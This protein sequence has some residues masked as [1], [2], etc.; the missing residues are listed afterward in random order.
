MGQSGLMLCPSSLRG[1]RPQGCRDL[2]NL[3]VSVPGW[4]SNVWKT[5][6]RSM[7][8]RGRLRR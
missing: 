2:I 6:W 3:V 5:A 4:Y 7:T 8:T 1:S